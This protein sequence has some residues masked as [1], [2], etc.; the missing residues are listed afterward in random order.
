VQH[1]DPVLLRSVYRGRVRQAFPFRFVAE[2]DGRLVFYNG[3]G[4]AGLHM[5][6]DADGRYLDRWVR[7]DPPI[8]HVW[9][10]T[11]LVKLVRPGEAHTVEVWWHEDWSFFRWYVNLQAP[12]RRTRLGWD[13]TDWAL[14]VVVD[15][16]GTP[17]WKDEDDFAEAIALGVFDDAAAA[18][19]RAEGERV[20]ADRPW[21]TGW[22]GWRPPAEWGPLPLP[23]G[24]D[25]VEP[26]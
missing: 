19:V 15:P 24:W 7:G 25:V 2:T 14:D 16:D 4:N 17:H 8:H 11:H 12:L 26:G 10:D 21:P 18:A 9:E 6:R 1:G 13:S 5:G 22:E 3:P 20:M 23:E